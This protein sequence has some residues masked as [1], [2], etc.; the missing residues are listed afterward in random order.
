MPTMEEVWERR[1][2]VA[3]EREDA[4][5]RNRTCERSDMTPEEMDRREEEIR[6]SYHPGPQCDCV[7]CWDNGTI[8]F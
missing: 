3:A 6:D 8:E 2:E 1:E 5:E 7:D 4:A